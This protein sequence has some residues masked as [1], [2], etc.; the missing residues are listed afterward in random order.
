MPNEKVTGGPMAYELGGPQR[1]EPSKPGVL[2][3][4][5]RAPGQ[6]L[7]IRIRKYGKVYHLTTAAT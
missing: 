1:C 7:S 6:P 4:E 3:F 2:E 5:A